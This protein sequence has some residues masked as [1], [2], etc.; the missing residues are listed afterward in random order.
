MNTPKTATINIAG[1]AQ[2]PA[3]N[4]L[5]EKMMETLP[6]TDPNAAEVLRHAIRLAGDELA[7]ATQ[8]PLAAPLAF[9]A[10]ER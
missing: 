7:A 6:G 2:E 8:A 1:T 9:P 5:R 4:A 10:G 3:F